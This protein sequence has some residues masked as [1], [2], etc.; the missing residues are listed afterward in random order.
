MAIFLAWKCKEFRDTSRPGKGIFPENS[1]LG[2]SKPNFFFNSRLGRLNFLENSG[3][4][5]GT[6][7]EFSKIPGELRAG[8]GFYSAHR[9]K[10]YSAPG[11]V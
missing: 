3:L 8:K 9:K 6:L 10:S 1:S 7:N 11:K 4:G 5:T 2:T